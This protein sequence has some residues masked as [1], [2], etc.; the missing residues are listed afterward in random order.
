MAHGFI[1]PK[2][3]PFKTFHD[4]CKHLDT[5]ESRHLIQPIHHII[6]KDFKGQ[7]QKFC[8][9]SQLCPLGKYRRPKRL[10]EAESRGFTSVAEM[11]SADKKAEQSRASLVEN[12]KQREVDDLRQYKTVS[13]ERFEKMGRLIGDQQKLLEYLLAKLK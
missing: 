4:E 9:K 13:E 10:I 3:Y 6:D 5:D 11:D 8:D 1:D 12:M 7:E 2:D